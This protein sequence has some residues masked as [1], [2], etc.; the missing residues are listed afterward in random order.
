MASSLGKRPSPPHGSRHGAFEPGIA[1]TFQSLT[2]LTRVLFSNDAL[3]GSDLGLSGPGGRLLESRAVFRPAALLI[4]E[5]RHFSTHR[6]DVV[7]SI[8]RDIAETRPPW[9]AGGTGALG[10]TG[11]FAL[12]PVLSQ[13]CVP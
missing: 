6:A 7:P 11:E 8:L 10:A 4:S 12:F 3:V 2:A 9:K 1:L 5:Y 13:A